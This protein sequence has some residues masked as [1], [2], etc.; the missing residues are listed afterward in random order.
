MPDFGAR[1]WP[2]AVRSKTGVGV[3]RKLK[4]PASRDVPEFP[5][6]AWQNNWNPLQR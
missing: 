4:I 5:D 3:R 2:I 6:K 1:E